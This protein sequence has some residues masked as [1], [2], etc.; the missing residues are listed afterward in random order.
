MKIKNFIVKNWRSFS[1][2]DLEWRNFLNFIGES[3]SGKSSLMNALLFFFQLRD[4]EENN[5]KNKKHNL[6]MTII[7]ENEKKESIAL[8]IEKAP[9]E[10]IRYS[11]NVDDY[12]WENISLDEFK[13]RIS[14]FKILYFPATVDL[15]YLD[16]FFAKI[17]KNSQLE[18]VKRYY[19]KF[20]A[21][22]KDRFSMGYYRMLFLNFLDDISDKISENNEYKD[23]WEDNI[24]LWEKPEFYFKPQEERAC[25]ERLKE[26]SSLGLNVIISTNSSRFIELQAYKDLCIFRKI[27]EE[28]QV[29]QYKR[30]LFYHDEVSIFN[31]N[32][33]INPDRSELFFAKKV[34]LVEGQTDKI[35]LS[36]LAKKLNIFNYDYSIIECGSK[37]TIP[38]FIKLLNAFRIP[39]I[40]V[41]DIDNHKWR[42]EAELENSNLKNKKIQR[43]VN[44]KVGKIVEFKN[45]IE[46]EIYF[47]D[48]E[49]RNYKNKPFYALEKVMEEYYEIPDRLEQKIREI[50]K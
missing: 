2:I 41:Y 37:S 31:M 1:R 46:E 25:Y 45:D 10:E 40:A 7:Y 22:K 27:K 50:Y 6:K 11:V 9:K 39:Y 49:R 32:Y 5:I 30:N 43:L 47:E 26:N 20:Q 17:W 13:E 16:K 36:Y 24:L 33:W 28:I 12:H 19:D 14:S 3:N 44:K 21:T 35:V 29:F 34:I 38:Q 18:E 15:E 23:F 48:R 4:F 8:K 42:T